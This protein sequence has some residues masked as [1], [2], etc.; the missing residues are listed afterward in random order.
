MAEYPPDTTNVPLPIYEKKENSAVEPLG[1]EKRADVTEHLETT[2]GVEL[3]ET[4]DNLHR[5]AAIAVIQQQHTIPAT[6]KRMPT[7]KW[8]Y[9]FFCIFCEYSILQLRDSKAD[10]SPSDFS[11]NGARE[12]E[13]SYLSAQ[14]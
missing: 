10:R 1:D 7:S 13:M 14:E 2:P 5:S 4:T 12:L 9:I 6:G 11:N 8:E 3:D